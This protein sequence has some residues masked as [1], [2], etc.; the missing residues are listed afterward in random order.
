[1]GQFCTSPGLV[2]GLRDANLSAF[3]EKTAQAAALTPPGT[4]LYQAVCDRF[5][6]GVEK[7][8]SISG[9]RVAAQSSVAGIAGQASAIVLTADANTFL[10]NEALRDELFG[11]ATLIVSCSST[12]EMERIAGSLPGQLTASVHGTEE[13]LANHQ[14]LITILQRKAGRLIF[15]GFPTGVEVC[16]AMHHGGPYPATTDPHFTSVGTNAIKRFARPVCFQNFPST[17]CR[18]SCKTGTSGV[19]GGWS[20]GK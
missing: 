4:M 3:I 12:A 10:Q 9:V 18:P 19:F 13:D 16:A 14:T 5:H 15:N 1:V 20:M 8:R 7:T 2:F 6:E 17:R 11:P